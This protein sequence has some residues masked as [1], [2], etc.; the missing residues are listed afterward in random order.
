M[1]SIGNIRTYLG[2]MF[3]TQNLVCFLHKST[4]GGPP[5]F[6]SFLVSR[7][8]FYFVSREPVKT[9][10]L[11]CTEQVSFDNGACVCLKELACDLLA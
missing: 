4:R 11:E 6:T 5:T 8:D 9:G 10:N 7:F 2:K 3:F 1:G